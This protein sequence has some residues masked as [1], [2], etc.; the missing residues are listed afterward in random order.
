M[1]IISTRAGGR[2]DGTWIPRPKA[3][4]KPPPEAKG[5]KDG[6][7]ATCQRRNFPGPI[8]DRAGGAKLCRASA[9]TAE[10]SKRRSA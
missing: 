6:A 4:E 2:K 7:D 8:G 1:Q 5:S 3:L 10:R 9:I